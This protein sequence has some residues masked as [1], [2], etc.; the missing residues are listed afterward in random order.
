MFSFR[1]LTSEHFSIPKV[2]NKNIV[3]EPMGL[4]SQ[5]VYMDCQN[6]HLALLQDHQNPIA[7]FRHAA[8]VAIDVPI[9][10]NFFK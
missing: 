6:P 1:W 9:N 7:L 4:V 8:L 5:V 3:I 10:C 2:V